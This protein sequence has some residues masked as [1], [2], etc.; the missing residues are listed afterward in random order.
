M[1]IRISNNLEIIRFKLQ[2]WYIMRYTRIGVRVTNTIL[3]LWEVLIK[4]GLCYLHVV[5]SRSLKPVKALSW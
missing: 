1:Q 3:I 4:D 2:L 5:S